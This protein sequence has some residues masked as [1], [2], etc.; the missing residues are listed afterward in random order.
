MENNYYPF[1]NQPLPYD[2]SALEPF[3]D[4]KTMHLHHDRHLQTYIDNLNGYWN[5]SRNCKN[6]PWNS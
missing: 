2:Y 5:K 6:Y 4:E 3:I 1:V